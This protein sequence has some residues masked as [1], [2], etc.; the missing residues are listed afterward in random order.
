M[1]RFVFKFTRISVDGENI[2]NDTET[3]VW[4]E[5]VYPSLNLFG[6]VWTRH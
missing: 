3:I 4:A 2:E 6:L 1:S 5:T